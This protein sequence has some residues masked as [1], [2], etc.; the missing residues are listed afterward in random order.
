MQNAKCG[1]QT[2]DER[3]FRFPGVGISL[4]FSAFFANRP[5]GRRRSDERIMIAVQVVRMVHSQNCLVMRY[6]SGA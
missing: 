2:V 1:M 5:V 6:V 4:G 3:R